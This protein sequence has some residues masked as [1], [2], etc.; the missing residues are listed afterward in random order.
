MLLG[1]SLI[2]AHL[3]PQQSLSQ[4]HA[5][6][7]LTQSLSGTEIMGLDEQGRRQMFQIRHV[8]LDP[9]DPQQE[10]ALYTVFYRDPNQNWQ[11][12]CHASAHYEAKAM[13]LQGSWD[14]TGAYHADENLVSFSCMNGA[15]A[16][17]VRFG[18]K[19]WKTVAGKSLGELHRACVR[20]V[21]AD[22]CGDGIPHTKDGTLIN[23]YDH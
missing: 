15:L 3:V 6:R 18:Y 22:Y 10:T 20:M 12:L 13:T 21:R 8:E 19:P 4:S 16:K 17:C 7:P 1:S 9:E 11:N 23:L 14:A 5:I 2:T